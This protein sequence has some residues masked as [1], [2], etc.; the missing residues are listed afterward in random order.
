MKNRVQFQQG[1]SMAEFMERYGTEAKCETALVEQ[2][3]PSGFVCPCCRDTRHSR[4]ERG[5]KRLWQCHR[6]RHQVSVTAGTIFENTKLPLTKWFLAM[7]FM[8]QSKNNI[9]ALSLK[10]HLGVSYDTAWLLRHKL[11]A[12]MG[13]A[14]AGRALDVRVEIDDAYLGGA[15]AGKVGRGSENKVPFVAAVETTADGRPLF[16]RFDPMP[17]THERIDAWASKTLAPT[18]HALS[19]GLP[20]FSVLANSVETHEAIVVGSGKQAAQHPK[21]R[22]VNTLI[23]NFKTALSG[24]YHAFRFAKYAKRY[25]AEYAYRFNRRFDLRTIVV[26]LISDCARM[27]PHNESAIR[28]AETHR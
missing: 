26:S 18:T 20:S 13:D 12:V 10:R 25:F 15:R 4:F 17:F 2:R 23:S 22:W 14:E 21:F 5:G 27:L 7:F 1:L 28:L 9:S 8:T 19:D 3:W 16:V 11:M 24:T 6:C